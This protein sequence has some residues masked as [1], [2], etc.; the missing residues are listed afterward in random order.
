MEVH[1]TAELFPPMSDTE[2]VG[3]VEDIRANG[4]R[5]PLVRHRGVLVDG[6]NRLRA[7]ED[8]GVGPR[9]VEWVDVAEYQGTEDAV[10][11]VVSRWIVSINLHRRHLNESQRGL[12]AGKMATAR[13]GGQAVSGAAVSIDTA[14]KRLNVGRATAAKGK[15]VAKAGDPDLERAVADGDLSL[16]A[17][18]QI[19]DMPPAE[20][21]DAIERRKK[22]KTPKAGRL[23]TCPHC[24]QRF[25]PG[26]A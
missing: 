6:R 18:A 1:P 22:S 8:A 15:K 24:G 13:A 7:C 4:L 5:V 17:A 26:D 11:D 21:P 9:F 25:A 3:L 2:Y 14:A 12:I 16:N 19:A 20:R 10:D 23:V